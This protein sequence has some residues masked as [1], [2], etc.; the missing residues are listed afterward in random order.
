GLGGGGGGGGGGF[1]A[2]LAPTP[3]LMEK[4]SELPPA[5]YEPKVDINR[6]ESYDPHFSPK[7]F[8]RPFLLPLIGGLSLVLVDTLLTLAGP[9]FVRNGVDNGI[10]NHSMSAL[11][12]A[13]SIFL[14]TTFLDWVDTWGELAFTGKTAERVLFTLRI[15]IFSQLQRLGLNFYEKEMA[16]RIMTRMTTDVDAQSQLLQSGLVNALVNIFTFIGVGIVLF[17]VDPHLATVSFA[18]VPPLF[19]ATW[20]FRNRSRKQ[21]A[22]ARERIALVNANL[23]EG[24]SGIRVSQAF[25]QEKRHTSAFKEVSS[26][27]LEARVGAQRLVAIYFPFVHLLSDVA[28]AIVLGFGSHLVVDKNMAVGSLI[29]FLLL[30]NQFFSPI[31]QLSQ[32]FDQWQQARASMAKIEELMSETVTVENPSDGMIFDNMHGEISFEDVH[33]SYVHNRELALSGATFNVASGETVALVGETGAGKS[34]VVKLIAR[35]YDPN[36]GVVSVDGDDIKRFDLPSFRQHL[37]YVPQE[38][39][40]FTTSVKE[41]IAYGNP[42]ASPA[43]IEEAAT[44]VGAHEFISRLRHGY[45]QP[46]VAGGRS[47]SAGQ[48]QL[49]ALARAKLMDPSILLLDEATANLDLSTEAKVQRAMEIVS[50]ERTTILIAHRLQSAKLADRIIVLDQGKVVET[51]TH[52]ALLV[53]GGYYAKMWNAYAVAK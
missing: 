3:E 47:L 18:V 36:E 37:G 52:D 19:F 39:F 41:N 4:V 35:F 40:L 6:A 31:Q 11:F 28:I 48:R 25:N 51:G 44:A 23:Q 42:D 32:T 13:S 38:A 29:A 53:K 49:I 26:D 27:Y 10:L 16:G 1:G 12:I 50:K 22:L 34:T 21:Y 24:I 17:V 33:F 43:E 15:R 45:M 5:N 46:I 20:W 30:V 9:L 7:R 2:M 14:G 8:L